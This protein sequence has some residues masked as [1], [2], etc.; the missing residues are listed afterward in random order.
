MNQ[1]NPA[2]QAGAKEVGLLDANFPQFGEE[3]LQPFTRPS[4]A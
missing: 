1:L 2:L 4:K 3:F